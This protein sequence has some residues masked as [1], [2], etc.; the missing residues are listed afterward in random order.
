MNGKGAAVGE[1]TRGE[2]GAL[3]RGDPSLPSSSASLF[4]LVEVVVQLVC[5]IQYQEIGRVGRCYICEENI[6][7][8][9]RSIFLSGLQGAALQGPL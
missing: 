8:S 5:R 3:G 2:V 1:R 6:P 4:A 7:L 9:V